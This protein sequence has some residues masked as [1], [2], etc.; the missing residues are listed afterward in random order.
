M[1]LVARRA[2]RSRMVLWLLAAGLCL[3]GG[4]VLLVAAADRVIIFWDVYRQTIF[5]VGVALIGQSLVIAALLVQRSRRRR[6]E[7]A[8]RESEERFRLMADT[9]RKSTRLN[10]SHS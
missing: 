3:V 7:Q 6:V 8:L 2:G 10:S 4:Q 9:D 5:L 1:E